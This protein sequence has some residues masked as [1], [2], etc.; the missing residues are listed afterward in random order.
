[1]N[2]TKHAPGPWVWTTSEENPGYFEPYDD[3][4]RAILLSI[5]QCYVPDGDDESINDIDGWPVF[6]LEVSTDPEDP[7]FDLRPNDAD[8]RLIAAAP[9]LLEA[10]KRLCEIMYMIAGSPME[11]ACRYGDNFT[12]PDEKDVEREY[13][14]CRVAIAKAEGKP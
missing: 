12:P 3:R 1:M 10:C 9:E 5:A 14:R 6:V 2:E 4:K 7:E 13:M 11:L 8:A